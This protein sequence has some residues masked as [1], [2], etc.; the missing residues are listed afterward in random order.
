MTIKTKN[1]LKWAI[2]M[3]I[4]LLIFGLLISNSVTKSYILTFCTILGAWKLGQLVG[5]F[6]EIFF[7]FFKR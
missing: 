7:P 2:C 6:G 4:F 3:V 1:K 5:V